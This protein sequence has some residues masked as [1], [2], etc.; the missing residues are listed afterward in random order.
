MTESTLGQQSSVITVDFAGR[1]IFT[2]GCNFFTSL[3]DS[4]DHKVCNIHKTHF[5]WPWANEN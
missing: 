1:A 3:A 4:Y 2:I 5:P